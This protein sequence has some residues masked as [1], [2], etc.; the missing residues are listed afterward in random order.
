VFVF[1]F[2]TSV[3]A[4][5][6]YPLSFLTVS[7]FLVILF[8]SAL[9][10]ILQIY[11]LLLY[12]FLLEHAGKDHALT[13]RARSHVNTKSACKLHRVSLSCLSTFISSTF[14]GRISQT[15]AIGDFYYILWRKSNKDVGRFT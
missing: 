11:K 5:N 12:L 10:L 14:I 7:K 2:V 8:M 6:S 9:Y 3:K 15:F 1:V 4:Q 13:F